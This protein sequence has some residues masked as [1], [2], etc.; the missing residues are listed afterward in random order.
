M[1]QGGSGRLDDREQYEPLTLYL[2]ID[3]VVTTAGYQ[4]FR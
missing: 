2:D 4:P 3:G 1:G